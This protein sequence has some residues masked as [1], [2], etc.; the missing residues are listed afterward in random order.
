MYGLIQRYLN[1]SIIDSASEEVWRSIARELRI[2]P[3]DLIS[4]EVYDDA[5]T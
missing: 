4:Q 1:E 3:V 2:G 5:L